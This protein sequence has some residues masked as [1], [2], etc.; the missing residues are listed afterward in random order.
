[1]VNFVKRSKNDIFSIP[2]LNIIFKNKV[3]QLSHIKPN[4][5]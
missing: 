1:M 2:L 3:S 4:S 5:F